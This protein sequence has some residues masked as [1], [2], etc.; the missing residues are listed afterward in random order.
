MGTRVS[1]YKA[2]S[3]QRLIQFIR[4]ISIGPPDHRGVEA[5]EKV[6]DDLKGIQTYLASKTCNE[7]GR[8]ARHCAMFINIH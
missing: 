8:E 3:L 4:T 7:D 2:E 6:N 1:L 5:C